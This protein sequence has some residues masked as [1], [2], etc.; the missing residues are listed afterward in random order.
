LYYDRHPDYAAEVF[1][2]V[3]RGKVLLIDDDPFFLTIIIVEQL[4]ER[5]GSR[6][7]TG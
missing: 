5:A 2:E 1:M 3:S 6:H 7:T 4:L